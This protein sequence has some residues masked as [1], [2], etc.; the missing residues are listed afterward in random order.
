MPSNPFALLFDDSDDESDTAALLGKEDAPSKR[1]TLASIPLM[2]GTK[3]FV[4][5]SSHL[6]PT[7]F[8]LGFSVTLSRG[9]LSLYRSWPYRLHLYTVRSA[10]GRARTTTPSRKCEK[11]VSVRARIY[12]VHI[13]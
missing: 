7:F 6:L 4:K 5:F 11:H 13:Q 1:S 10:V 3:G 8:L 9:A 2:L 12:A